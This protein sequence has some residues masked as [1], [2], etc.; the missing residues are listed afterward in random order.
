MVEPKVNG[1]WDS[2]HYNVLKRRIAEDNA[3]VSTLPALPPFRK[4]GVTMVMTHLQVPLILELLI[5]VGGLQSYG[6]V[7][8]GNS[9]L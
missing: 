1:L 7:L 8:C 6:S 5:S 9:F 3:K 4:L 2:T